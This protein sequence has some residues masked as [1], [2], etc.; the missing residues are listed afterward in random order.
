MHNVLTVAF[1]VLLVL[2]LGGMFTIVGYLTTGELPFLGE[3]NEDGRRVKRSVQFNGFALVK[4]LFLGKVT[5]R[6]G[7]F[8][9]VGLL[10]ITNPGAFLAFLREEK[11]GLLVWVATAVSC[12]AL[13]TIGFLAKNGVIG[14]GFD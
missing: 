2:G 14:L 13:A 6:H 11:R 12:I 9:F 7:S 10:P 5:T 8:L 3:K 1:L 4:F